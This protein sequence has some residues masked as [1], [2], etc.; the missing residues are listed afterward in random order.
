M[1]HSSLLQKFMDQLPTHIERHCSA[2]LAI[3]VQ[4]DFM[5]EGPLACA[6]GEDIVAPLAQLMEADLFDHVIA[7]QDWHPSN[8]ISF[9]SQHPDNHPFDLIQ[10]HGHEQV[11]WPDHCVMNSAGAA[12]HTDI[13]WRHADLIL[14]KGFDPDVDSYSAF[15]HNIDQQ[16]TRKSTGLTGWL[17]DAGVTEL[18]LCGLAR[19]VCVLW[20][21]QD[22]ADA[23]FNVHLLWP[24]TRPVTYDTNKATL[25]ALAKRQIKILGQAVC[26]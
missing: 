4:S 19:D 13:D 16:G 5:A 23:G 26:Q 1:T 18:Y 10:L 7:T 12:L 25:A 21:A 8:H 2:L 9:I 6:N 11:L 24:L 3:D 15:R 20:S 14:R 22:A 17:R